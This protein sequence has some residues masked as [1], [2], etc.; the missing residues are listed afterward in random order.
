MLRIA[1]IFLGVLALPA[2]AGVALSS[3]H[4]ASYAAESTRPLPRPATIAP[5][6]YPQPAFLAPAQ[7][8]REAGHVGLVER[9]EPVHMQ[10]EG[11]A[12]IQPRRVSAPLDN[13]QPKRAKTGSAAGALDGDIVRRR[14]KPVNDLKEWARIR[15]PNARIRPSYL[16]GVYR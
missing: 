14:A 6:S 15:Y 11:A 7:V 10:A 1:G 12:A 2:M 4:G 9:V 8:H 3:W 5:A 16:I 13:P